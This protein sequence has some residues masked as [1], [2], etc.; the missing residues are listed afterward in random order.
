MPYP[1]PLNRQ[2]GRKAR[3]PGGFNLLEVTLG[4]ALIAFGMLA[5]IGLFQTG[6]ESLRASSD[7]LV[8]REILQRLSS[9]A[10]SRS[11]SDRSGLLERMFYF[12][13]EGLPV[14]GRGQARYEVSFAEREAL[15]PGSD[16]EAERLGERLRIVEMSITALEGGKAAFTRRHP[17][18]ISNPEG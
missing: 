12:D 3:C 18:L 17:M 7:A 10:A 2:P 9:R 1:R 8:E 15:Y 5:T 4:L 11:F 6:L 16:L 13:A 14:A